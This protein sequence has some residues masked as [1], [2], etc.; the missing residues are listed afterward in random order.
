MTFFAM[1]MVAVALYVMSVW[2]A[3]EA[4]QYVA[5]QAVY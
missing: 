2:E 5:Q 4:H 3:G 1:A